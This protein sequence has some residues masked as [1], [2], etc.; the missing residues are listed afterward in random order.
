[1][2]HSLATQQGPN[3]SLRASVQL[4]QQGDRGVVDVDQ[5]Q[6]A[7]ADIPARPAAGE[8]ARGRD[9][10]ASQRHGLAVPARRMPGVFA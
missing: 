10:G 4:R 8:N 1:M 5:S 3:G 2:A 9:A 7:P 6:H